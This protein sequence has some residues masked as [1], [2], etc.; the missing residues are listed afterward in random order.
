MK[1][2]INDYYNQIAHLYDTDRFG[3]SY[4]RFIDAQERVILSRLLPPTDQH[5]VLDVGCGTGRFLDYATHGLDGSAA[6]L[7]VAHQKHPG[8]QLTQGDVMATPF[9]PASFDAAFCMHVVMHLEQSD[10]GNLLGEMHRI[11]KP[12]GYFVFDFPS[13]SRRSLLGFKSKNW[14]G[15]NAYSLSEV[16]DLANWNWEV[17]FKQGILFLPIHRFPPTVRPLLHAFD[18]LICRSFLKKYASYLVVSLRKK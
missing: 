10:L 3:N 17:Q 2:E 14:H 7:D 13:K 8:K 11:L 12:N 1:P 15:R 9:D 18:T 6:M 16:T 4:G 5:N